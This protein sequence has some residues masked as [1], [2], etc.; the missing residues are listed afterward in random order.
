MTAITSYNTLVA[1]V[2]AIAEDDGTE[3]IAY[4]PTAIDLAEELMFKELDLPDLMLKTNGTF[5]VNSQFINKPANYEFGHYLKMTIANVDTFLKKRMEDYL[6]DYWPNI[7]QVDVPKYYADASSTQFRVAPTPNFAHAYELKYTAKPTKLS[8]S[9]QT[10]YYT[11]KCQN[12]LFNAVMMEMAKFMKAWS[13]VAIFEKTYTT[14]R[15]DWNIEMF[16]K[17]RDDGTVPNG[18]DGPNTLKHTI[19]TNS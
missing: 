6:I 13:Q 11:Q 16:R 19:Q 7:A 8:L 4:I 1:A 5:T 15:D 18:T 12:I 3:F 10:N 2:Q 9:N 17:R 14:L